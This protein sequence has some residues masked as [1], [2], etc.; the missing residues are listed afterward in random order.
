LTD[1]RGWP[2]MHAR[3]VAPALGFMSWLQGRLVLARARDG[4]G[5]EAGDG[6][7]RGA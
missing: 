1:G 4:T 6:G 3:K 5:T 7:E 2:R